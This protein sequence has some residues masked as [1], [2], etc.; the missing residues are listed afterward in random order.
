MTCLLGYF[1]RL[2]QWAWLQKNA[3]MLKY[4]TGVLRA[5]GST[6]PAAPPMRLPNHNPNP[7]THPNL[8]PI[9]NPNPNP[10]NKIK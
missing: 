1:C 10:K 7:K 8:N 2:Q 9:F 5:H 6:A 4:E 3:A